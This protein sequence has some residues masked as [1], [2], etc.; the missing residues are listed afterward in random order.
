VKGRDL[1]ILG[2]VLLVVGFAL[3]DTLRSDEAAV[4]TR[5]ATSD[6]GG[7]ATTTEPEEDED[8]G[9]TLMP[10]VSGA[11]GSI[12]LTETGSCAVREFDL[13]TGVELPNVVARSTCQLWAAPVTAK[14]AVGIAE[15]LSDAVPFRFLDLSRRGRDLGTSEAAFGFLI[16]SEDGQRAAWCNSRLEG[17]DLELGGFRR[18]LDGCPAAYTPDG[19]IVYARGDRLY[20]EDRPGLQASGGITGVHYGGDGSV[21]VVVEGRRVERY[22]GERLTDALD[23]PERFEGR[24]PV[25]SPDNC[26]AAFRAGER[27]RILDVGCSSYG[28]ESFGGHAAAWSPDGAWLAVGGADEITFFSLPTGESV[29]WPVGAIQLIWRRS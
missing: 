22:T 3:A 28:G 25:L 1:L 12:V 9:R 8:L 13:P 24:L 27:I 7:Q 2:A 4:E 11:P 17:I 15:P 23:L 19:E 10:T 21:A 16:W 26:S 20:V 29:T 6:T 18:R 5:P 14:V